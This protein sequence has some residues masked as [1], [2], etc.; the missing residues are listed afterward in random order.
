MHLIKYKIRI[1]FFFFC[2][3]KYVWSVNMKPDWK[4]NSFVQTNW[5]EKKNTICFFLSSLH[6]HTH[7]HTHIELG[8]QMEFNFTT[9]HT[10]WYLTTIKQTAT[11]IN[12]AQRRADRSRTETTFCLLFILISIGTNKMRIKIKY[13]WHFARK[14]SGLFIGSRLR[15]AS[16]NE[17]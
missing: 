13:I 3:S 16:F 11:W 9:V 2:K 14:L 8:K 5:E 6:T 15:G 1:V 4:A 12:V 10:S 17:T 7:T